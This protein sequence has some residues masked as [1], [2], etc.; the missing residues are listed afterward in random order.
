[1]RIVLKKLTMIAAVPEPPSPLLA[2]AAF[3]GARRGE[4]RGMLWENYPVQLRVLDL[5]HSL[6]AGGLQCCKLIAFQV[7]SCLLQ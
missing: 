3:N 1:M 6:S 7:T 5:D 4:L 2:T